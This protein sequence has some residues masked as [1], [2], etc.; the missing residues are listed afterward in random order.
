[1]GCSTEGDEMNPFFRVVIIPLKVTVYAAIVLLPVLQL[2]FQE[3]IGLSLMSAWLFCGLVA[4]LFYLRETRATTRLHGK[5][6]DLIKGKEE[7]L[8]QNRQLLNKV[9]EY[10]RDLLAKDER[11]GELEQQ[12]KM[13]ARNITSMYDFN[14]A[15]RET[16]GGRTQVT[17][18][19]EFGVFQRMVQ[20]EKESNWKALLELCEQQIQKTPEWLTPYLFCGVAYAN[21]GRRDDAIA[22]LRY[23]ADN[24]PGDPNYAEANEILKELAAKR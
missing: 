19:S 2:V 24:A 17:V 10:Q 9:D 7:L 22:K 21:L 6:D 4:A 14:G 18:G 13:L 8:L 5:I 12:S 20:L 16:S 3:E 11:I 23:V 15:K 1:M